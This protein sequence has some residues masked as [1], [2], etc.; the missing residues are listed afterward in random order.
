VPDNNGLPIAMPITEIVTENVF[1]DYEAKYE[2]ASDEITPAQISSEST[3]LIKE[4]ALKATQIFNCKGLVRVDLILVNDEI[5]AVIEINAV[6]G[7]TKK[8]ILPQQLSCVG[9]GLPDIISRILNEIL[10]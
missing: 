6:P 4:T 9:I 3:A 1:F 2:G 10:A 7:F 5:P 8:S